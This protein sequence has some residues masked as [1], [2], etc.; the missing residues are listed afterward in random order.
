MENFFLGTQAQHY[1]L[2]SLL[3]PLLKLNFWISSCNNTISKNI[4]SLYIYFNAEI[5]M[6]GDAVTTHLLSVAIASQM[7][8]D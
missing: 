6:K 4:T 7:L 3:S 2:T 1:C 5:K 8:R